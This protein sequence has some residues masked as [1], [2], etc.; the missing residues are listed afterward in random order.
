M[1]L[2]SDKI[3]VTEI[4]INNFV[5]ETFKKPDLIIGSQKDYPRKL[6]TLSHNVLDKSFESKKQQTNENVNSFSL[7]TIK[8][9]E[10]LEFPLECQKEKELSLFYK[11]PLWSGRPQENYK[12]EVLKSGIILETVNL[13]QRNYYIIGRLPICDISMA[14]PTISRYHAILQFRIVQDEKNK[15]GMY[16]YDLESTHG[17]FLNGNRIKPKHYVLIKHSDILYFGYSQRK[18]IMQA[19][20]D[21]QTGELE[22]SVTELKER[23]LKLK[24][25]EKSKK[26][27]ILEERENE[28]LKR[29]VDL[30][31]GINWGMSEDADE[32]TDLTENPYAQT[33][34][35]ELFLDDPKKSLRGWFEREGYNLEYCIEDKGIGKFLCYV[36]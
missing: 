22:F 23:R 14:H 16:V 5:K 30:S 9:I 27:Q 13:S 6:N 18:F 35:E 36:E 25:T 12:L 34:N 17:T 29:Q 7:N 11:E 2:I 20:L 31:E 15:K 1:I 19:P 32:E 10:N 4:S 33:C 26:P 21:S 8:N 3:H 24:Q 28:Q